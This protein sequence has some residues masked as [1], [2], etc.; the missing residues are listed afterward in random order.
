VRIPGSHDSR[1]RCTRPRAA[2]K[3]RSN[4]NDL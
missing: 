3:F 1:A 2:R 4:A